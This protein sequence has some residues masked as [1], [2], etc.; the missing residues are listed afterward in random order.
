M[1]PAQLRLELFIL[2][3][4]F[5]ITRLSADAALPPWATR[6]AFSSVTRTADEL[7]II[8]AAQQ[9]PENLR[10]QLR[11]R[12]LKLHG[13]FA[14][15]EVGILAPLAALLADAGISL[16]AISTFDTDYLLVHSEQLLAAVDALR[17][18]GYQVYEV[19]SAS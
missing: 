16:F 1:P 10:D 18:A 15:T 9:V 19:R 6:G 8:C 4:Q 11:W 13:P 3:E 7:S 14:L 5:A 17:S 12:A 2:P